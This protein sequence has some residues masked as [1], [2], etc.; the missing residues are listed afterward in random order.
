MGEL[1]VQFLAIKQY[2]LLCLSLPTKDFCILSDSRSLQE[3][4]ADTSR[5]PAVWTLDHGRFV[6]MSCKVLIA[7][8]IHNA[9]SLASPRAMI[10]VILAQL[11]HCRARVVD[12]PML[13][14]PVSNP[15]KLLVGK[16]GSYFGLLFWYCY[17]L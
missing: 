17:L 14:P 10:P 13:Y 16:P 8:V 4:F 6:H 7:V 1:K 9:G 11:S 12:Y 3:K 5:P 15:A 2:G